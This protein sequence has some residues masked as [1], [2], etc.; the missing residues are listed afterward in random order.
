MNSI[1]RL[2]LAAPS[3]EEWLN[4]VLQNF[5]EFLKDHADCE[6]KAS[7]MAMSFVAKFPDR[8]EIIPR[9]ID[10][11]VEELQHFRQV[12]KI[13]EK[14]GVLLPKQMGK[15]PYVSD[16]I[17]WCRSGREERFMDR[18][19]LA[20]VVEY[21]GCERFRMIAEA[22]KDSELKKFYTQLWESEER[23]GDIFIEMA[24]LYFEAEEV[25]KRLES[26]LPFE[27]EVLA[28]LELRPALH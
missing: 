7:A 13:M 5:D 6:R 18:L 4:T 8:K 1:S 19:I 14:R 26:L 15:D 17:K 25:S 22:L 24:N 21:R 2:T 16:L 23:H 12:Y 11:A 10:T 28:G 27:A 20:S 3:S 9:L